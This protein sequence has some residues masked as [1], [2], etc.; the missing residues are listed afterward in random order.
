MKQIFRTRM[1][2]TLQDVPLPTPGDKEVLVAVAASVISTGTETMGM[3][4]DGKGFLEKLQERKVQL[5]KVRKRIEEQGLSATLAT[6]KRKLLPSEQALVYNPVG[7]SNAGTVIA[8]GR[9][10]STFSIGDRVACAGSG[11]ANHAQY[12][13]VPVNLVVKLPEGVDYPEAAFATIGSIAMQGLRRTECKPGETVVIIGLGLLGLLGVQIAK[14]W[15]LVVVG[16]DLNAE[17]LELAR[18]F[19]ADLCIAAGDPSAEQTIRN[20]TQGH[21]ADSVVIY[22]A[23]SS[24]E[25]ANQA[26]RFCRRKGRVVVVG[27]IGMD[28]QREDMYVKELDFVMST[29]YGP[30]RYDDSYE[31]K[32]ND[33]PVGY[34]RWTEN[35]NMQEF[36][37]MLGAKTIDVQ[38]LISN[39]FPID[40]ASKA[41]EIL[42]ENPGR[43]IASLFLYDVEEPMPASTRTVL[44][45]PVAQGD[46]IRVGIIGAGGFIQNTHM[47]NLVKLSSLYEIA[48]IAN[49]TPG[50]SLTAGN[51]WNAGYITTDY[52]EILS[53]PNI[54]MVIIGT[55][56]NLHAGQVVES[57]RAGKHLLVEKPLAMSQEELDSVREMHEQH[58]E[59]CATV[60]FNR[61]YAPF[62]RKV[63]EI[64]SKTGGPVVINYRI[65]AGHIPSTSWVQDLE[66][67]GG[68]IHGELCHFIDL[69]GYITGGK[70]ISCEAAG[71]PMVN[72]S[73][74]SEDN[75]SVILKYDNGSIGTVTYTS[76]GGKSMEKERIEIFCGGCSMVISDFTELQIFTTGVETVK[77]KSVEKGHLEEME[78]F[79]KLIHG[80]KSLIMPFEH[81]ILST[82]ATI[83]IFGSITH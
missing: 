75:V 1:G 36:V 43:N 41:Y 63:T 7:Y 68:R 74:R 81:D 32:G 73:L 77:L 34:V 18:T 69:V 14:A 48:A 61:R 10:V 70:P 46:K 20:F 19:G 44:R 12:A 39:S 57:I 11:I 31:V 55:R 26:M 28:L 52:R 82:Q 60:G 6:I 22:A 65:N 54:Q 78:E 76:L 45:S 40:E 21:G 72:D 51:K 5:D 23:T 58:P 67:G 29:S 37:R 17:R 13:S 79:A 71:I 33:Y 47:P 64:V 83:D 2:I 16:I 25:P 62:T 24:S 66:E 56:H 53:D 38:P 80:E 59:V 35:R 15:G 27:A 50:E 3:R 49:R 30:G 8:K 42:L 9:L 4:K